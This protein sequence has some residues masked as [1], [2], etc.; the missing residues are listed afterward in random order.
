MRSVFKVVLLNLLFFGLGLLLLE[1]ILRSFFPVDDPF[2]TLKRKEYTDYA[3]IESQFRPHLKLQLSSN[4][5][6]PGLSGSTNFSINNIGMRG[7]DWSP[8]TLSNGNKDIVIIGGSTTECL[9]L[10][11]AADLSTRTTVYLNATDS[12]LVQYNVFAAG[13][14]GDFSRDHLAMLS[15]RVVHL[16]PAVVVLFCGVNDL[17]RLASTQFDPLV[18]PNYPQEPFKGNFKKDLGLFLSYFQ[19]YRRYHYLVNR[20]EK[21][22][23]E[24]RLASNYQDKIAQLNAL[25]TGDLYPDMDLDW[26]TANLLSFFAIC[27]NNGITPILMTQA[28]TWDMP[29]LAPYHWMRYVNNKQYPAATMQ[30]HMNRI[31]AIQTQLASKSNVPVVDL[32][33]HPD[34]RASFFYDDCHF[35][36]EGADFASKLLAAAILEAVK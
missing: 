28:T 34:L 30:Q 19:L 4:E 27:Q 10:D 2:L 33:N 1:V 6:M 24:I 20:F 29:S 32:A 7:P 14:S 15:Q 16:K 8:D 36:P 22:V 17:R 13:K 23:E 5:G 11:D 3:F 9:Y 21:P 18:F 12:G 31:N 26:F 25:P 35:T